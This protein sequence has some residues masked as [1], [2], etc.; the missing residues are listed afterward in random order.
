MKVLTS[1]LVPYIIIFICTV[2][3]AIYMANLTYLSSCNKSSTYIGHYTGLSKAYDLGCV[4]GRRM[5]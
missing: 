2:L 1:I 5:E 4:L 3:F